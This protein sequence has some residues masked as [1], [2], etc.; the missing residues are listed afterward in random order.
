M[1][2]AFQRVSQSLTRYLTLQAH[3]FLPF[4][5]FDIVMDSTR[6]KDLLTVRSLEIATYEPT[7]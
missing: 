4:T 7:T 6:S 1:I 5:S 2:T 3:A